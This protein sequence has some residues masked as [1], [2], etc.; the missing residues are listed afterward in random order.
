MIFM[1]HQ[2]RSVTF[3]CDLDQY[4]KILDVANR[5]NMTTTD[6]IGFLLDI[7]LADEKDYRPVLK[8]VN[9]FAQKKGEDTDG[10]FATN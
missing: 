6:A 4:G 8:V 9:H 2:T 3:R 5:Y 7:G 1:K 10:R